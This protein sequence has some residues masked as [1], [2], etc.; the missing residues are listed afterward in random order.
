MILAFVWKY[1]HV[2]E[3]RLFTGQVIPP[4]LTVGFFPDIAAKGT[5]FSFTSMTH[6]GP[7]SSPTPPDSSISF[8]LMPWIQSVCICDQRPIFL[9]FFYKQCTFV[10]LLRLLRILRFSIP[11]INLLA[12]EKTLGKYSGDI[13][14]K[15]C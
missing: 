9:I 10:L 15:A 4:T 8:T 14:H 5:I 1:R 2:N 3:L 11:N 6:C 12:Y 13:T 7:D